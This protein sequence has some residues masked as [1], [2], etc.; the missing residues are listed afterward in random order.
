[1]PIMRAEPER[2]PPKWTPVRRRKRDHFNGRFPP[3]WTPV[4]RRKRD[5]VKS[6]V[7]RA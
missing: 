3:K 7:N 4:R 2:F 1:M 5:H 6:K